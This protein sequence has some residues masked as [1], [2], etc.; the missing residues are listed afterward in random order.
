MWLSTFQNRLNEEVIKRL[1]SQWQALGVGATGEFIE[2]SVDL[3][4]LLLGTW[5]YGR[6]EPRLFDEALSW[7]CF[8]GQLV[9]D[10]RLK[11]LL[12]KY[13]DPDMRRV[14][15]AWAAVVQ[16]QGVT[17]D[18]G[19]EEHSSGTQ[20]LFLDSEF[21]PTATGQ[22][23]D[24][25]F[26]VHGWN[27]GPFAARNLAKPDFSN[28]KIVQLNT[29][30]LMGTGC[31]SEVF[32]LLLLGFEAT[33]AQLARMTGYSQRLVQE[34]VGDFARLHLVDWESSR[35]RSTNVVMSQPARERYSAFVTSREFRTP[36]G[37]YEMRDWV[38]FYRGVNALWVGAKKIADQ[39]FAGLKLQST[40]V[41]SLNA[42]FDFHTGGPMPAV[43]RPRLQGASTEQLVEEGGL[44][45]NSLFP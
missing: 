29:R 44:Y 27:R 39:D 6:L 30:L 42:A 43:Y 17:W 37:E 38:A 10:N 40:I 15:L 11:K 5:T 41:D 21:K 9:H 25:V 23:R 36:M 4:A 16:E 24:P 32:A 34:V 18:L 28:M 26:E 12:N 20:A 35:G 14:A 13:S 2:V 22:K 7:C 8:H 1:W 19:I 3:E 45:L 31:R 33:T